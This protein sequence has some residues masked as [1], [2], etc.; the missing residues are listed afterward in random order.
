MSQSS[1]NVTPLATEAITQTPSQSKSELSF[2]FTPSADKVNLN[3]LILLHGLGDTEEPYKKLGINLKLPQTATMA[4]QAP[5]PVPY[6][7][8]GYQWFPSFDL[9]TGEMLPPSDPNRMKGLTRTRALLSKLIQHL[10]QDCRYQ[11]SNI[12]FFGFSQGGTVALDQVMF[13]P[14]KSLGGVVSVS[15]YLLEE[16][17]NEKVTGEKYKGNILVTQGDND[18]TVGTKQA[19][20]KKLDIIKKYCDPSAKVSHFFVPGKDHAMPKSQLEWRA[21]HTFFSIN[22]ARRNIELENMSDVYL[23]SK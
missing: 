20:S 17:A 3:V 8:D 14:H 13:G 10:I 5:E 19:A 11:P 2:T 21:I 1:M 15:G 16:Q 6:M 4:V 9:L 7:D 22:L 18:R 23:V 12:F